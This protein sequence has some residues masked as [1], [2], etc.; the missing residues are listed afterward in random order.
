[1]P[2]LTHSDSDPAVFCFTGAGKDINLVFVE[3]PFPYVSA[4]RETESERGVRRLTRTKLKAK[5]QN[6]T[7]GDISESEGESKGTLARR[8]EIKDQV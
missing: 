2:L 4:K 3:T 8:A 5:D 1:M 6:E 7:D